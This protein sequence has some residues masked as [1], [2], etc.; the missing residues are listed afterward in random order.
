ML[1]IIKLTCLFLK[2]ITLNSSSPHTIT[3]PYRKTSTPVVPLSHLCHLITKPVK[4]QYKKP[5]VTLV[6][7]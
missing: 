4:F 1:S 7:L 3:N 6:Q 5:W 2:K